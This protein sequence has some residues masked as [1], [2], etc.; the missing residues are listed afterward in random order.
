M[1]DYRTVNRLLW[2]E[3]GPVHA[4]SADYGVERFVADPAHLSDVVR[5]DLP[6]LGDVSGLNGIHLQCHIGTDTLSLHRLGAHMS[7]LDFSGASLAQARQ[8]AGR[9][10]AD[11]DY[12]ESDVYQAAEVFAA[13][14]V[15]P[16]FHRDRCALLAAG[17]L[18]L[19][20]GGRGIA[21]TRRAVVPSGQSPDVGCHR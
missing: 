20:P 1:D 19:G 16:G 4:V 14:V 8:L 6:L 12:R 2:D 5:F 21:E 13:A 11:I 10:G 15:R 17:Y 9:A 18:C 3:R 7:G